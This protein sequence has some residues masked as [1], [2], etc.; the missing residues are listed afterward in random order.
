MRAVRMLLL[1]PSRISL[2]MRLFLATVLLVAAALGLAAVGFER[3]ARN[4]VVSA[5]HSH[6]TARSLE[7]KEAVLRFQRERALSVR[8]WSEI[9][10][11]Q[12]SLDSGD[13]KFAEDY[14]RRAIQDQG[15]SI[16]AA[17]LLD[18]SGKVIAAVRAGTKGERRGVALEAQ[19][20]RRI[21]TAPVPAAR[22]GFVMSVALGRLSDVDAE[23][24]ATP[25]VVVATPVRDFAADLVGIVVASL[26]PTAI[27]ELLAEISAD[28]RSTIPLVFDRERRV[29]LGTP[30]VETAAVRDALGEEAAAGF[31]EQHATAGGAVLTVRTT[32]A[33]VAPQW[34][35]AMIVPERLAFGGLN[36]LRT[37]LGAVFGGVLLVAAA[38]SVLALQHAARPLTEVT[39]S[40]TR[41][42]AGDLSTRLDLEYAGELGYLVRSFNTMVTEVARSRDELQRTEALRREV[43]IAH[44]IQ[45]AILPDSPAVQGFEVAARMKTAD[46]VGGDLYDILAFEKTFWVLVGDVSGH[47]INS[48]LVMMMAQAAAYGAIADDPQTMPRDVIAAVNRVVHENVRRRMRRDDYLTLMAARH[49]GGGR[50]VAAG[51]HQPIFIARPGGRVD[52]IEPAGPWCGLAEDVEPRVVEYEFRLDPGDLLCLIT[53]GIVE[54]RSA[55]EE[56]FGEDRLA[57]ILRRQEPPAASQMLVDIFSRVEAFAPKQYDDMTAVILRRKHDET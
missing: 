27:R 14:L 54:A 32:A 33:D 38:A 57:E 46:D 17:A 51:A 11:M 15:G 26:S 37:I 7:F 1:D 20:G 29:V 12:L 47:G 28:D 13:P 16:A 42:A 24:L 30:W 52:V 53:D 43:Q 48:G 2:R 9:D 18:A 19:R 23:A 34:A 41:V 6:L 40:M 22:A 3:A 31:L 25:A 5:V 4:V 45:T 56:L 10:A 36:L 44:Q 49:L 50:F 21:E 35:A 55:T 8:N 39:Q